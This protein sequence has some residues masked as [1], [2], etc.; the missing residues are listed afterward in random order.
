MHGHLNARF[1]NSVYKIQVSLKSDKNNGTLR[2]DLHT[3]MII[4][5]SVLRA[6]NVSDKSCTENQNTH[7]AVS[8]VFPEIRAVC[9]TT[10]RNTV[11]TDGQ[12]TNDNIVRRRKHAICIP[13]NYGKATATHPQY[14]T[15]TAF[16][17]QQWL[18][19]R[20]F[21]LLNTYIACF[22]LSNTGRKGAKNFFTF[23]FGATFSVHA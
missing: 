22:L 1:R 20:A 17:P 10:W 5:C 13:C 18:R 14:V 16:P 15:L 11:V 6:R 7:Y 12:T 23:L 2:E 19:E 21:V 4:Y 8:K 9:E 3:F